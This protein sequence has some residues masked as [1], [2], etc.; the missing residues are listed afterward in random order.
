MA[1]QAPANQAQLNALMRSRLLATGLPMT[2]DLGTQTGLTAGSVVRFKILNAGLTHRIRVKA[3][4]NCTSAG[5]APVLA[6]SGFFNM[7]SRVRVVDYD[8]TNRIDTVP[9][10]L[11][12]RNCVRERRLDGYNIQSLFNNAG[13]PANLVNANFKQ[14]GV[15]LAVGACVVE[16]FFDI[17]ICVDSD[18]GDLRGIMA[19][20]QNTGEA[21]V[22]FDI[23]N[24]FIGASDDTKVF[25]N[26]AAATLSNATVS[27]NVQQEY[28]LQQPDP[29]LQ[30]QSPFPMMD[31]LTVYEFVSGV[32]SDNL[33]AGSFKN[34]PFP[35]NRM[36]A[37]NYMR[38]FHNGFQGGSTDS[39]D[40]SQHAVE[41]QGSMT[42]KNKN[43]EQQ[44]WDQRQV[45]GFDL[46]RGLY[47]HDWLNLPGS[48]RQPV[49]VTDLGNMNVKVMPNAAAA[50]NTFIEYGTES[51]YP[52]GMPLGAIIN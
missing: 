37:G 48:G 40:L 16:G 46:A 39:N 19:S 25:N 14:P 15:T 52:K 45:I 9:A 22:T 44:L 51:L 41:L 28:F 23:A 29:L 1:Q 33:V 7:F 30:G 20:N 3:T 10:L 35:V 42:L 36:I 21:Y 31:A 12:A 18:A 27:I 5:A 50:G 49:Q 26:G 24:L 17:P 11:H 47:F 13:T 2:Q 8:Q 6:P 38:Y 32:T 34:I 4:L 43:R